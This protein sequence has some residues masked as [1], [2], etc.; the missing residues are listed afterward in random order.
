MAALPDEIEEFRDVRWQREGAGSIETAAQAERFIETVGFA[1]CLTDSRKPGPSLYVAVCGR[2]DAVMPRNVQKDPECSHTWMLKDELLRRGKV[3]Y[4]KLSRGKATFLAPRMIQHFRT[5]WGVRRR[6]EKARLSGPA[7]AVLKALRKEWE[8]ASAD[9][10]ADSGIQDR[11]LFTVALDELQA[12]MIV[13]PTEVIYEPKF[14]Y[15]WGLAEERF[16]KEL[17][18]TVSRKT[19]L[20]EVARCFLDGAGLTIRGELARVTGLSRRDAGLG[21]RAL[22]KE[23]YAEMI[24]PGTYRKLGIFRLARA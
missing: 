17:S 20:R 22:V 12:A 4:G 10:R 16:P 15:L 18:S 13:V 7:Q 6:E 24:G 2:R 21:N 11:R 8:M 14:T 23:G 5:L 19:A 9:L 1:S 3:Y